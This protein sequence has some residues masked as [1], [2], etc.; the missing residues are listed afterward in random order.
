MKVLP[1]APNT[2][3]RP[4]EAK[5]HHLLNRALCDLEPGV[6]YGFVADTFFLYTAAPKRENFESLSDEQIAHYTHRFKYPEI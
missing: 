4:L 6:I 1:I 5:L 3:P 2:V